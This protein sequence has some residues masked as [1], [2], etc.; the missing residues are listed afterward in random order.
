MTTDQTHKCLAGRGC[1]SATLEDGQRQPAD[2]EGP[3]TLCRGC[4]RGLERTISELPAM[5]F[6]LERAL[7]DKSVKP[8]QRVS[9]TR[10]PPIPLAV[11]VSA[12]QDSLIEWI[13]TAAGRVA[14]VMGMDSP[15]P[16]SRTTQAHADAVV[17]CVRILKPN[18]DRL[19]SSEAEPVTVW[20]TGKESARPG[21]SWTDVFGNR[22]GTKVIDMTGIEIALELSK[23]HR[24][25]RSML[26]HTAPRQI[27][28]LPCLFCEAPTVYRVVDRRRDGTVSDYVTCDSCGVT[29]DWE[30]H[31]FLCHGTAEQVEKEKE[32]ELAEKQDRE[33][34]QLRAELEEAKAKAAADRERLAAVRRL[35]ELEDATSFDVPTFQR[36]LAELLEDAA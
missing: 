33:L 4:V 8:Q 30:Q 28:A 19:L 29:R 22:R 12:L 27:Q 1:A 21:E 16:E 7:G 18:L 20:L 11:D 26:G 10:T 5:W 17:R 23:L 14:D 34:E 25:A 9:G 35:A 6:E 15:E 36:F 13:S 24:L 2:T 3:D 31:E 32:R